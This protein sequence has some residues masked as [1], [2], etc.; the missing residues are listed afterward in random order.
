M[1]TFLCRLLLKGK[2]V[3]KGMERN[4]VCVCVSVREREEGGE[5]ACFVEVFQ[6]TAPCFYG[7]SVSND[8][9]DVLP[10]L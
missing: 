10:F 1:H 6:V 4:K 7:Y 8:S 2:E 3:L 5:V 9:P